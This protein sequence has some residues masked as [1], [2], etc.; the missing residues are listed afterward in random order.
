[1]DLLTKKTAEVSIANDTSHK[2]IDVRR[3]M[4]GFTEVAKSLTNIEKYI[5]V[6]ST[7][8]QISEIDD[9]ELIRITAQMF[10]FISIDVGYIIPTNNSDWQYICTRILDLLKRYYSDLTLADI[11][12]AFELATMGELNKYLPKDSKG[13]PDKNHYQQFNAEYFGKILN[14]YKLKRENTI[15]NAYESLPASQQNI[16]PDEQ[17]RLNNNLKIELIND[18]I[19]YKYHCKIPNISGISEML[20]YDV[21]A[22]IG[23]A[24]TISITDD[25]KKKALNSVMIRIAGGWV[26]KY[27][28]EHIRREGVEHEDVKMVAFWLARRNALIKTFDEIIEDEIQIK[29]F[30]KL[31]I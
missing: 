7:K 13:N 19:Y 16:I 11:K 26:N 31:E 15:A 1:M 9:S 10:K 21:L 30:I 24:E 5:F 4:I 23:L 2:A 22:N 8:T 28:A 18:L 27:T 25:E 14:A 6:A 3:K 29:N 12:L 20:F 17:K